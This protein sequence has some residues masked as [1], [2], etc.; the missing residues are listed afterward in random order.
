MYMNLNIRF[1]QPEDFQ[2]VRK[3]D[4]HSKYI[5][6]N[7]IKQKLEANEV[8]VALDGVVPVGLIKFSNFWATRPYI[9]LI[10]L[11]D[12]YR[13]QG[14]GKQLLSFL[15]EYLIQEGHL[16][17]MTSSQ[18]DELAPQKWHRTQGFLPCG[19]LSSL[20]LPMDDVSEVFFYKK[21]TDTKKKMKN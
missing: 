6:P 8:I 11:K 9:D 13:G 19:E 7:K 10:W 18:K 2:L 14:I 15:E 17:L 1:V 16:Y 5:D 4:P 21:L 20:N 3:L 12:E